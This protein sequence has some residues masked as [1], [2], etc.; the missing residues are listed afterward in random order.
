MNDRTISIRGAREHNLRNVALQIPHNQL[1]C[2][3]G[4]SGSGKSSLAF[5]TLYAEGQ[6]RYIESLSAYARQFLGTLAKPE[7]DKITGLRPAV[8]IQ[9]KTAGWNPRS[10]VGTVTGIYDFLRVLFARIGRQHCP[11]CD[12]PIS[13]QTSEAIVA[14]IANLPAESRLLILAPVIRGQKGEHIDLL[15]DLRRQ[16]YIRARIDGTIYHLSEPPQLGRHSRH[17][18]EVV[19]DR[20]T[21]RTTNHTRLTEAVENALKIGHGTLIVAPADES[22]PKGK[23]SKAEENQNLQDE[24]TLSAHYA[25][26][27]CGIGF[28]PPSPQLFSFNSPT[29]LCMTCDGMGT[30]YDFDPDL[31]VPDPDLSFLAPCIAPMRTP[32][33][34]WRRHIYQGVADHLGFDLR[35]PWKDLPKKARHALLYGTG[36]EHITFKWRYYGRYWK[37][38]GTFDGVIDELKQ[39]YKQAKSAGVR[40]WYE[41]YMRQRP[42][43]ECNGA[44]LNAQARAVRVGEQTMQDVTGMPIKRA[45]EFFDNLQLNETE[46]LIAEEVLKEI[47]NRLNFLNNVGLD[48]L[49]LE[50]TAPTLSGGESQRIRLAGQI[51]SGLVG[52]LYVLDEPSIGLHPR[53]N[54][55]LLAS[56]KKLRDMGNTVII[57]EHDEDT[58][59]AADRIVDFGPGPGVRGGDIIADGSIEDIADNPRSITGQYLAGQQEIEVPRQRR[60]VDASTIPDKRKNKKARPKTTKKSSTTKATTGRPSKKKA[61]RKKK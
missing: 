55:Q 47:R 10:T 4:V 61:T 8:A 53:D 22:Q 26:T 16:G 14:R 27:H 60:P 17:N 40:S 23:K 41:K 43:P 44:R 37:H 57:V 31:L 6:R 46:R 2:F 32:P 29:G 59:R 33:G 38:G 45:A 13:A 56:L 9:Q 11:Q 7:V 5:D 25:C 42:C 35:T 18:I 51:G 19:V 36:D 15:E 3:T 20:I 52:V 50:R 24:I 49:T 30:R 12:R 39:K 34:R 48:Y 21:L 58:M 54:D 1:I 28:D